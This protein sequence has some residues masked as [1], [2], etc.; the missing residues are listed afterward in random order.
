MK[1]LQTTP[2]PLSQRTQRMRSN[3]IREILK[4]LQ[5]PGMISFAGGNPAPESFPMSLFAELQARALDHF[6]TKALQYSETEGFGPFRE[7]LCLDLRQK[8][9]PTTPEQ[10]LV[11]AGSQSALDLLAKVFLDTDTPIGVENPTY[12]GA[13]QAFSPYS[14]RFIPLQSDSQ[15]VLPLS[16]EEF[17]LTHG[18][19]LVYLMPTFQNPSGSCMDKARRIEIA[20]LFKKY[21]GLLIEDDPYSELRYDGETIAPIASYCPENTIYLGTLSKVFA[22][23]LRLGYCSTPQ[24]L[25]P[26]L[27]K[28]KQGTDLHTSTLSQAMAFE[29]MEG[30]FL[31]QQ[32]PIIIQLYRTRRDAMQQALEQHFSDTFYWEK[33]QGGMFFWLEGKPS[34]DSTAFANIAIAKGVSFVPG[35]AFS[36]SA[37]QGVN[38]LRLNFSYPSPEEIPVGMARLAKALQS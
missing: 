31:K 32:L 12:L 34:F 1:S 10:I 6:G 27:V 3:A 14:P 26:W 21:G 9:I 4:N 13:L 20:Q 15:G 16:L 2:I 37:N 8:G 22:P 19:S 11:T 23:G 30:G 25:L 24:W 5:T 38:C 33:P 17:F 29:Y 36:P 7:Q 18:P 28:A 35:H